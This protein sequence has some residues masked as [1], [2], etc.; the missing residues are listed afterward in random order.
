MDPPDNYQTTYDSNT[1]IVIF[2]SLIWS[3]YLLENSSVAQMHRFC[4]DNNLQSC[5]ISTTNF[6]IKKL[7]FLHTILNIVNLVV[8]FSNIAYADHH[9]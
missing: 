2:Y 4:T 5:F 3:Y 6:K 8:G 9:T 7:Y 1:K